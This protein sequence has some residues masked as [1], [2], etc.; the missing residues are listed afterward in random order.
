MRS[1]AN[2]NGAPYGKSLKILKNELRAVYLEKRKSIPEEQK[3]AYDA[4]ICR[5]I[6]ASVS[7]RYAKTVLLYSPLPGEIDVTEVA[8]AALRD[9]KQVAFP[10]CV[11]G[12]PIMHFHLVTDLEA[13]LSRG[14]YSIMEPSES[15]PVWTPSESCEGVICIIPAVVFDRGG[16]RIGYGKGYYDR[17]LSTCKRITRL[18]VIYNDFLL[19]SIPT[20][21][22]DL[23]ADAIITEKQILTVKK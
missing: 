21:R 8:V 18:G 17:Y 16:H 14:S 1:S 11:P 15:A 2:G 7:Y 9:G 19:N 10:R 5:K 22:F 23:A 12:A 6:L 20:G 13:Q 4:A 3:K